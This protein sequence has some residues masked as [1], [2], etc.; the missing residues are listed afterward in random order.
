MGNRKA[1]WLIKTMTI[2]RENTTN[3]RAKYITPKG[4]FFHKKS[5]SWGPKQMQKGARK[6]LEKTRIL[7]CLLEKQT[8]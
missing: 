5:F 4:R 2:S 3:E 6:F 1:G 8:G 7:K